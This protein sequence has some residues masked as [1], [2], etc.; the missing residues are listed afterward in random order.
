M[1]KENPIVP[2]SE[3][4]FK[5]NTFKKIIIITIK[6]TITVI[7]QKTRSQLKP[8]SMAKNEKKKKLSN[9]INKMALNYNSEY[10]VYM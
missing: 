10:R 2:E 3:E 6:T 5:I 1:S 7:C 9:K 4:G 8:P